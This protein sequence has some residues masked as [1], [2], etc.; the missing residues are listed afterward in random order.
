MYANVYG[1]DTVFF[2]RKTLEVN[3][4]SLRTVPPCDDYSNV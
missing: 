1:V 3:V 4:I 2:L